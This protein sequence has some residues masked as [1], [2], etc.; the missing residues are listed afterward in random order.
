[1][2]IRAKTILIIGLGMAIVVVGIT[3]FSAY[4]LIRQSI[5]LE[6]K[7]ASLDISRVNEAL[8]A[9]YQGLDAKLADWSSW[10]DTYKYI[11]DKNR[12]YVKSNIESDVSFVQSRLNF[13]IF[14]DAKSD[15]VLA[16]GFDYV[17]NK[18]IDVDQNIYSHIQSDSLIVKQA[19]ED[20]KS[21]GVLILPGGPVLFA[22]RPILTSD[23]TGPS[24]GTL[25]FGRFLS[26]SEIKYIQTVTK[27]EKIH[28][29]LANDPNLPEDE[30]EKL[31]ELIS[32]GTVIDKTSPTQLEG[33]QVIKD[34]YGNST[35]FFG[36][37]LSRDIYQ[38]GLNSVKY[39]TT[40]LSISLIMFLTTVY[41]VFGKLVLDPLNDVVKGV[42]R[43][44][45]N[46]D[47]NFR[48]TSKGKDEVAILATNINL[49]LDT[50]AFAQKALKDREDVLLKTN[51]NLQ[52]NKIAMFN[53]LE[54]EKELEGTLSA[55]K[56]KAN[57]IITSMGDGLFV[58][59]DKHQIEFM[60][61]VAEKLLEIKQSDAFGK[62]WADIVTTLKGDA[63]ISLNDRSTM[64]ALKSGKSVTTN[65]EDNHYYQIKGTN[66]KFP[67]TSIT[68]PLIKNGQ[69]SGV[70]KVFKDVS[71]D[72]HSKEL[73][74]A[75]VVQRTIELAQEKAK[76]SASIENMPV[77]F[78]MTD[79]EENILVVNK[80]AYKN[81]NAKDDSEAYSIVKESLNKKVDLGKY[82]REC[83]TDTKTLVYRDIILPN[84][85]FIQIFVS[86]IL[87]ED[88]DKRIKCSGIVIL[89]DD[90]TEVKVME[91]SK[92]EFFSIASHELRT[93]LTAIKGNASMI[94]EHYKEKLDPPD[95]KEMID[96]IHESSLRLINIVNDFLNVSRLEQ[97]R[98][99]FKLEEADIAQLIKDAVKEYQVT[100]SRNKL[101][102]N[103]DE[104]KFDIPKVIMDMD[105][106]R[107]VIINLIGNAIKFTKEGGVTISLEVKDKEIYVNVSD[108]GMG[109]PLANQSLLF[110]K[111]Q[112]AGSSILTRDTAHGTGLGLYISK[113]MLEGMGGKI[114]LEKSVEGKGST[115]TFSIPIANKKVESD[116][117]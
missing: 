63:P 70:V 101:Y 16:R 81:L 112:Q 82:L 117:N 39:F 15:L 5:Q 84:G 111:F 108:T 23:S 4:F 105:R 79:I 100:G 61:P 33:F 20:G 52:D 86:P 30:Q 102:L 90:I 76:L 99:E 19:D 18:E 65:L 60:N 48:L 85:R 75:E 28:F 40:I 73:V 115:F 35:L 98:L 66:K 14:L 92:D 51:K 88:K 22:A 110:H 36:L 38:Q 41:F 12:E 13:M 2:T 44:G 1:M 71:F 96:D 106:M 45:E 93:P 49:M 62:D 17:N 42:M 59:N 53:I 77:G 10:D 58:L 21:N 29:Y 69:V 116:N 89:V 7:N 9:E 113:L 64:Q 104:P 78:L 31:S 67:I 72:K 6:E 74:E 27:H 109:I 94:L 97:N 55:E 95:F 103:F 32:K 57:A 114:W 47:F 107:Q 11:K 43:I 68:T 25:I 50:L 80:L 46:K 3:S 8:V 34:I 54:D 37:Y 56:E 24:R 91:R 83:G 87:S 26:D